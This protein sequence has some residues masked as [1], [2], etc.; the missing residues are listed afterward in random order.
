MISREHEAWRWPV[1]CLTGPTASGK[2]AIAVELAGMLP[3]EIISVDSAQVYRGM[4]IGTAKPDA[5]V[6]RQIAHHL[7]DIRDPAECYS[8]G[9][10]REDA[11]RLIGEIR[12]RGRMPLLVGGTVLY[13][14]ALWQGLAALPPADPAVRAQLEAEAA[15]W[16]WPQLHERLRVSDPV[17]AARIHANDGQRIQRALEVLA[18]TGRPISSFWGDRHLDGGDMCC[19]VVAPSER[20]ILHRRIESRLR[21]MFARGFIDEVAALRARGD[22]DPT[23]PSMRSVG[24]RQVLAYLSGEMDRRQLFPAVL[25]ATRQL[26]KRQLTALRAQSHLQWLDPDRDDVI[27]LLLQRL[28]PR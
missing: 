28:M 3:V 22:L 24:Y 4:D 5:A 27:D 18:V 26:A 6:R 21:E 15:R 23:L 1:V 8:A 10:F 13:F 12:G 7:L 19:W 17:A 20:R 25:A 16:G 11:G 14:R 9:Q 2:S